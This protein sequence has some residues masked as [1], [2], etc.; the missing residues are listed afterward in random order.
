MRYEAYMDGTALSSLDPSI[1]VLDIQPVAPQIN[2]TFASLANRPGSMVMRR[3]KASAS[4]QIT[5]EIH[6]YNIAKRQ[7]VCQRVAK[8]ADGAILVTN[9][10]PDQR[11]HCI[12]EQYPVVSAKGWTEPITMTFTGYLIPYWEEANPVTVSLTGTD[13][14]TTVYIPGNAGEALVSAT[15]KANAS[16]SSFTLTVGDT[17]ITL[18][19]L[20]MAANDTVTIAYDENLIQSIK[21]GNTSILDKRTGADDL[22]AKS[23]EMVDFSIIASASVTAT[24]TVRGCWN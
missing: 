13:E 5:F 15:V 19:G 14:E 23:G 6:E 7:S 1:L 22:L 8:W 9:D 21:K 16:V 3:K 11:L 12:C 24:F 20:S 17:S 18:S 2:S 10:R 4:V